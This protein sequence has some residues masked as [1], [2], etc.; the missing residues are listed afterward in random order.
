MFRAV[1]LPIIR[2]IRLYNS[3]YG[4]EHP[5]ICRP[6]VWQRRNGGTRRRVQLLVTDHTVKRNQVFGPVESKNRIGRESF[7]DPLFSR[8]IIRHFY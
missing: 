5:M 1:V 7:S 3:A 4:M 2:S 8:C 6:V